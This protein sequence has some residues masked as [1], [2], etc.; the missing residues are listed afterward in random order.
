[1]SKERLTY[2]TDKK[3]HLVCVPY[4]IKNLHKM[5]KELGILKCWFHKNHYDI[6]QFLQDQ[7]ESKCT[8]VDTKQIV[9]IIRSPKYAKA[10]IS[11]P[12]EGNAHPK[13]FFL[14]TQL[15]YRGFNKI[16]K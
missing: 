2:V 7:V 5:A 1:M 14:Q 11:L 13:D 4:S 12:M 16:K 3:R 8:I 15:S 6:P 9:E 10:I